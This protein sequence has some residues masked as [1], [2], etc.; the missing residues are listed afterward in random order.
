MISSSPTRSDAWGASNRE[1]WQE[2]RTF[3]SRKEVALAH[4]LLASS[5][6]NTRTG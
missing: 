4:L 1:L 5:N 3:F 2:I 6:S